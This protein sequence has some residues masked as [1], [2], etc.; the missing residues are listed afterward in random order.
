MSHHA[1]APEMGSTLSARRAHRTTPSWITSYSFKMSAQLR[2]SSRFSLKR[3]PIYQSKHGNIIYERNM[4][5]GSRSMEILMKKLQHQQ[6]VSAVKLDE[7]NRA[8]TYFFSPWPMIEFTRLWCS[9]HGVILPDYSSIKSSASTE[10]LWR[11]RR[12]L[13]LFI[14]IVVELP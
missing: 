2:Q 14:S 1:A 4:R 6:I 7:H 8:T 10:C 13:R 9:G 3:R 5:H 11:T 12:G